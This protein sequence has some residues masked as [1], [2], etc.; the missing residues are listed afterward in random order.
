MRDEKGKKI[1]ILYKNYRKKLKK[2]KI[3]R[4]IYRGK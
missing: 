2:R 1:T 3:I 4:I